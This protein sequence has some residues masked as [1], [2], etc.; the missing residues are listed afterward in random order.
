MSSAAIP[1]PAGTD[2]PEPITHPGLDWLDDAACA[3]LDE[4]DSANPLGLFFVDAGH[5]ISE[6][7]LNLCRAC[8][9]R[10]EC[11]THFYLGGLEGGAIGGGY[12]GGFSLGQ[13]KSMT[14]EQALARAASER[15]RSAR[16][17]PVGRS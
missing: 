15:P 14:L 5:V 12:G 16:R 17:A 13:R 10:P 3:R 4:D 2:E 7:T 8:P 11:V 9:V 1:S 6:D